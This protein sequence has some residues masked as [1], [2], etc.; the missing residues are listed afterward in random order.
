M[1]AV[2]SSNTDPSFLPA[3]RLAKPSEGREGVEPGLVFGGQ[4]MLDGNQAQA[5][6]NDFIGAHLKAVASGQTYAQVSTKAMANP[7]D[8]TL[9]GQ[10]ATLFKGETLRGLLLNAYG[11]WQ[12]GTYALY[13]GIGLTIAAFAV[14]LALAFE[15]W[16]WRVAVTKPAASPTQLLGAPH[17]A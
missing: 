14:L 4:Q 9:A 1:S 2:P 12:V 5:Y 8:A 3:H 13:A 16:R 7:K 10:V 11:W 17:P 15:V 6:A